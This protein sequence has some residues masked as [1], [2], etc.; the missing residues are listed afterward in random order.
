MEDITQRKQTDLETRLAEIS[1][2][3]FINVFDDVKRLW[4]LKTWPQLM[5]QALRDLKEPKVGKAK[6]KYVCFLLPYLP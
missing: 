1:H 2:I 5:N 4:R 3:M 6:T